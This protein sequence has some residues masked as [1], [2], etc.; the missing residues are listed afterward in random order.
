MVSMS[1]LFPHAIEATMKYKFCTPHGNFDNQIFYFEW[2]EEIPVAFELFAIGSGT[3]PAKAYL[4]WYQYHVIPDAGRIDACTNI[5][6]KTIGVR[7]HD[8]Q[9][10]QTQTPIT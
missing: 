8:P 6:T 10:T 4:N 1:T 9:T 5:G 3:T 2:D 7:H